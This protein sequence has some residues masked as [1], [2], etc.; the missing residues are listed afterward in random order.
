MHEDELYRE[1]ILEHASHPHHHG[2]VGTPTHSAEGR[3][4]VCGD[5]ISLTWNDTGGTLRDIAF[6]GTGCSISQASASILCDCVIGLPK[7]EALGIARAFRAM[8]VDGKDIADD[9]SDMTALKGVQSYP[10]RVKCALL[11]WNLLADSLEAE[12]HSND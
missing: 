8:L 1:I 9:D 10:A 3:N 2:T 5:E 4:P 12:D 7:N 6:D 11:A